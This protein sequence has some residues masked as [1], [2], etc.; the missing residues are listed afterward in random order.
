MPSSQINNRRTNYSFDKYN[1]NYKKCQRNSSATRFYFLNS[2]ILR[3][4]LSAFYSCW[5]GSCLFLRS[6]SSC[7]CILHSINR[8]LVVSYNNYISYETSTGNYWTF[9]YFYYSMTSPFHLLLMHDFRCALL[10][11]YHHEI[12]KRQN[13]VAGDVTVGII[14]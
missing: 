1:W 8:T 5:T 13:K 14:F 12:L 4:S 7:P 6:N 3:I 11:E 9:L 10:R 2:H